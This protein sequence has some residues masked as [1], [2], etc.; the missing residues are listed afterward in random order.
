MNYYRLEYK[1][2]DKVYYGDYKAPD[3]QTAMKQLSNRIK[4]KYHNQFFFVI[5]GWKRL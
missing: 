2:D 4:R 5:T 3:I 1:L